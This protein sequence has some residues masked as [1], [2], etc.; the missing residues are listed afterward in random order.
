MQSSDFPTEKVD[1]ETAPRS[2]KDTDILQPLQ[3]LMATRRGVQMDPTF[4]DMN[5]PEDKY[6]TYSGDSGFKSEKSGAPLWTRLIIWLG[7]MNTA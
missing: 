2:S 6:I 1:A 4:S 3:F 7:Y 5:I